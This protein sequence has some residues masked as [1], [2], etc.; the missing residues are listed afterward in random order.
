MGITNSLLRQMVSRPKTEGP[1][2]RFIILAADPRGELY[3]AFHLLELVGTEQPLPTKPTP[4]HGASLPR[5][6]GHRLIP[7]P[8][9]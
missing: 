5:S 4:A 7:D 2:H 1:T 9:P 6:A 8:Y 3:G